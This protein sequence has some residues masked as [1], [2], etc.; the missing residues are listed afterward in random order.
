MR[1]PRFRGPKNLPVAYFHCVSRIVGREFLLGPAEKDHFLKLMRLYEK[2]C[3]LRILSYCLMSNHFHLLVEVPQR[4][5]P[6]HLP[7]DD[8]LVSLVR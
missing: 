1:R 8:A 6:E 4:P 2:L 7:N 3:G 5:S